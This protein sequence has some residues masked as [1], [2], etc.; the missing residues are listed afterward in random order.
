M[1]MQKFIPFGIPP[2]NV[3]QQLEPRHVLVASTAARAQQKEAGST[4]LGEA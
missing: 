3:A 4:G 2:G 1:P